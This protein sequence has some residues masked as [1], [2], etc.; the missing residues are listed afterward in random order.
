LTE[1]IGVARVWIA[2]F[3]AAC[4][5]ARHPLGFRKISS[6]RGR[7]SDAVQTLCDFW[8]ASVDFDNPSRMIVKQQTVTG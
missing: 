3:S 4:F 5:Y 6:S 7:S 8:G 2:S 1:D